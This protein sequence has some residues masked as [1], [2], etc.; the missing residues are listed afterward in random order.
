MINITIEGA[1]KAMDAGHWCKNQFGV[2]WNLDMQPFADVPKY[3]FR[4]RNENDASHFALRW[5]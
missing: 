3:I 5:L 4:F 1:D 2:N